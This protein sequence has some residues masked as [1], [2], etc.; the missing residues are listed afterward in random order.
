M[1]KIL[2]LDRLE[3]PGVGWEEPRKMPVWFLILR[4]GVNIDGQRMGVAEMA[5]KEATR[6]EKISEPV[7]GKPRSSGLGWRKALSLEGV[8][9]NKARAGEKALGVQD[10]GSVRC[11]G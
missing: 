1:L 5:A 8:S 11:G 6:Q 4:Q 3:K 7:P 9:R 2:A 10:V